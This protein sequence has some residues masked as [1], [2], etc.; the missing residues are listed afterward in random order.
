M[1]KNVYFSDFM[2]VQVAK[3]PYYMLVQVDKQP[4]YMLVAGR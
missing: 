1:P 2:L 4:Y 3:Q